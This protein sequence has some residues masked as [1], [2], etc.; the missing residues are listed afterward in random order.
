M[1]PDYAFV[2]HYRHSLYAGRTP[3]TVWKCT[4]LLCPTI[5]S[6]NGHLHFPVFGADLWNELQAIR[7]HLSTQ[8][9]SLDVQAATEDFRVLAYLIITLHHWRWHPCGRRNDSVTCAML[10]LP[11]TMLVMTIS[12]F[13]GWDDRDQALCTRVQVSE[14]QWTGLPCWESSTSDGRPVTSTPAVVFVVNADRAGDTS[15]N[16]GRRCVSG[17]RRPGLERPTRLRHVSTNLRI[18]PYCVEDVY[19]CFPGLSDTDNMR[20]SDFVTWS[21]SASVLAPR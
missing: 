10:N 9:S 21:W 8:T 18:I 1:Y 3:P 7:H 11:V 13:T 4:V 15:C 14:G 12:S 6:A 20:H 16:T 19:I 2:A 5:Q 17:R